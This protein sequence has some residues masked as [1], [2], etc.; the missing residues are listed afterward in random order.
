MTA[1]I[2]IIKLSCIF[3]TLP[4]QSMSRRLS[5]G[6][7]TSTQPACYVCKT[8]SKPLKQIGRG[9]F[10]SIVVVPGVLIPFLTYSSHIDLPIAL[11]A[12]PKQSPTMISHRFYG[13]KASLLPV[14]LL[15]VYAMDHF[16]S[17]YLF[18][19]FITCTEC[20]YIFIQCFRNIFTGPHTVEKGE[21]GMSPSKACI[22]QKYGIMSVTDSMIAYIAFI[23]SSPITVIPKANPG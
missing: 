17:R 1:A 19:S 3:L 20:S 21:P 14:T 4:T 18:T 22:M 6:G 10:F 23:V 8:C 16:L 15:R 12:G 13:T 2:C 7:T 5:M 11:L 9:K